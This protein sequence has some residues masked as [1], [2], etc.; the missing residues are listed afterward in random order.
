MRACVLPPPSRYVSAVVASS[1]RSGNST[2]SGR[3]AT[4]STALLV[5]CYKDEATSADQDDV[6]DDDN[7]DDDDDVEEDEEVP[8]RQKKTRQAVDSIA[9]PTGDRGQREE[10]QDALQPGRCHGLRGRVRRVFAFFVP[11]VAGLR[12]P[13]DPSAARDYRHQEIV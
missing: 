5:Y 12:P 11:K 3:A 8:R 7:Y 4:G 6:D 1:S 10:L 9:I 2:V 13:G